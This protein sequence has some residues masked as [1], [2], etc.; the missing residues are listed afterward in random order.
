[1]IDIFLELPSG[2]KV[3]VMI[4]PP[5]YLD[6][7]F[8][9]QQDVVNDIFPSLIPEM[10][11]GKVQIIDNFS[12]M[13]GRD[14]TEPNLFADYVHP[15]DQGYTIIAKNVL[16]IVFPEIYEEFQLSTKLLLRSSIIG[17]FALLMS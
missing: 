8:D 1:M 4:P 7:Q 9:I 17:V 10:V 15:N 11:G 6:D 3:Y 16:E 5:C 12:T 2:P 14:L 13:G